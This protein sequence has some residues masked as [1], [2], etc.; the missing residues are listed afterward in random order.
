MATISP[1]SDGHYP[2][3]MQRARR[4]AFRGPH[5]I[6]NHLMEASETL[7]RAEDLGKNYFSDPR[8]KNGKQVYASTH[9]GVDGNSIATYVT[10]DQC[11][12]GSHGNDRAIH[13]E[14]AGFNAQTIAEWSDW[15]GLSMLDRSA[16]W[17]ADVCARNDIPVLWMTDDM[18][19]DAWGK[20]GPIGI[21]D[22]WTMTRV[23][24]GG[25]GHVDHFPDAIRG[26]YM[27]R[28]ERY[29]ND[30][31]ARPVVVEG[32]YSGKPSLGGSSGRPERGDIA[33]TGAPADLQ[34]GLVDAGIDIGNGGLH[35]DGVDG[36]CGPQTM[37]GVVKY[38]VMHG[39]SAYP[40]VNDSVW[41]KIDNQVL[42]QP[43]PGLLP[44]GPVAPVAPTPTE[45]EV[46]REK[47]HRAQRHMLTAADILGDLL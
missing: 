20:P 25:K 28:V 44:T 32:D 30:P 21:A 42:A 39:L 41:N 22:H 6:V 17:A 2:A 4:G 12:Y 33:A 18:L 29:Y 15:F 37:A 34:Q 46:R 45:K 14:H 9:N 24:G 19:S 23:L 3:K 36:D 11:A 10:E 38:R 26:A 27:K 43:K 16:R 5:L 35:G 40:M 8:D 13:M 31:A 1:L 47:I 7:T